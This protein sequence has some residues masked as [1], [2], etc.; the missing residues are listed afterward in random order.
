[1]LMPEAPM[2]KDDLAQPR[3]YQVGDA[4]EFPRMKPV[5]EPHAMHQTA[6][7]HLWTRISAFD[8]GHPLTTFLFGEIIHDAGRS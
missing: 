6:D 8:A 2:N 4:G 1:M 5:S 3:E 7:N